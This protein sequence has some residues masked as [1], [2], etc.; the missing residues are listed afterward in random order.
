MF[1]NQHT[2]GAY[3][4]YVDTIFR[5]EPQK[6][7]LRIH[8]MGTEQALTMS[9]LEKLPSKTITRNFPLPRGHRFSNNIPA[10][11]PEIEGI[12]LTEFVKS[13]TKPFSK[14]LL[15]SEVGRDM[16]LIDAKKTDEIMIAYRVNK[17]Q[18][19]VSWGG[20]F[21]ALSLQGNQISS[22]LNAQ[23]FLNQISIEEGESQK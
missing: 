7:T 17:K 18:I 23:F 13:R 6:P 1:E 5:G 22:K 12:L 2:A 4:W 19:P 14:I 15:K 11:N 20:P 3:C 9:A 21:V 16:I 10:S 8:N